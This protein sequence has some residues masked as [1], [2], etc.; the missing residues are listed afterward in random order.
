MEGVASRENNA[1]REGACDLETNTRMGGTCGSELR[2]KLTLSRDRR[3]K[4]CYPSRTQDPQSI[5]FAELTLTCSHTGM[6][7]CRHT[8]L[9]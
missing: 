9:F 3:S 8:Q 7:A 1:L 4:R 2:R 6:Q 5:R